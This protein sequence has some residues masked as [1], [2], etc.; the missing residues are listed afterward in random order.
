MH[1]QTSQAEQRADR[2]LQVMEE[3]YRLLVVRH[4]HTA[5]S[6]A[7]ALHTHPKFREMGPLAR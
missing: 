5:S 1:W 2:C 7:V 6:G 4:F 3:F